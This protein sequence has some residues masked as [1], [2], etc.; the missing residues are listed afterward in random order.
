MAAEKGIEAEVGDMS[1][2]GPEEDIETA[3]FSRDYSLWAESES[4]ETDI[5][6]D[7]KALSLQIMLYFI[8]PSCMLLC[9]LLLSVVLVNSNLRIEP[10]LL[11]GGQEE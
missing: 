10:I 2:S 3:Y 6:L 5:V 1:V 8:I 7:D 11:L 9:V 4:S